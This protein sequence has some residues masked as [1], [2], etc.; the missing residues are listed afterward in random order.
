[1]AKNLSK[2]FEDV[3]ELPV[4]VG[5]VSGDPVVVGGITGVCLTSRD[6]DGNALVQIKGAPIFTL[7][8]NG[9]DGAGNSA[10]AIGD[11]L[12]FV[13]ADPIKISKK[14]TGVFY[15]YALG[16][17]AAGASAAIKVLLA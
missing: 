3:L 14:A 4:P 8:V 6:V 10:V 13:E 12:Y 11:K 2:K 1:M 9:V 15:G 16:T 17:V 5:Y 7:T